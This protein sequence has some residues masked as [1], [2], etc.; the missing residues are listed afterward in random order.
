MNRDEVSVEH[1]TPLTL[2][3]FPRDHHDLT[4]AKKGC[5]RGEC[6]TCT[7][8]ADGRRV[9][10]CMILLAE[11]DSAEVTTVEGRAAQG[12]LHPVQHAGGHWRRGALRQAQASTAV[13]RRSSAT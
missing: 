1:D 9:N 5:N 7:V 11:L 8:L 13:T 12:E 3:D 4:G 2:L 6:G 10:G